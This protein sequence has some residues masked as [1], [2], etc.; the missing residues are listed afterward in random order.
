MVLPMSVHPTAAGSFPTLDPVPTIDLSHLDAKTRELFA[1]T[2][3]VARELDTRGVTSV[4]DIIPCTELFDLDPERFNE[5]YRIYGER[6]LEYMECMVK[7]ECA[8]R[9]YIATTDHVPEMKHFQF[10]ITTCNLGISNE[11]R[12]GC[13]ELVILATHIAAQKGLFNYHIVCRDNNRSK[14]YLHTFALIVSDKAESDPLMLSAMEGSLKI[15][16]TLKHIKGVIYDPYLKVVVPCELAEHDPRFRDGLR[17]MRI[18]KLHGILDG[19]LPEYFP[20]LS[21]QSERLT[22]YVREKQLL[23]E[24][25]LRP[26][27]HWPMIRDFALHARKDLII[28]K[29]TEEF[30]G[31]TWKFSSKARCIHAEFTKDHGTAVK[32]TLLGKGITSVAFA[33]LAKQTTP[34]TLYGIQIKIPDFGAKELLDKLRAIRVP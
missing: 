30:P 16:E 4:H 2:L 10:P 13:A 22:A 3:D 27:T 12:A 21:E 15:F 11:K 17:A 8:R 19:P 9:A 34:E 23:N 14:P 32:A 29:L 25:F 24:S 28:A 18:E 1:R 7:L 6:F 20:I 26:A 33:K 5:L 31:T